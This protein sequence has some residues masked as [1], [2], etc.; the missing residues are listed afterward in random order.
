[1]VK[2]DSRQSQDGYPLLVSIFNDLAA[3]YNAANAASGD[4]NLK[5]KEFG[6][7]AEL[8][9]YVKDFHYSDN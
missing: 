2:Q 4:Y 5:L 8:E 1:M 9:A 7:S 6:T 3:A